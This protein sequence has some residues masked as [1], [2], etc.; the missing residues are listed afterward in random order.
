[1]DSRKALKKNTTLRFSDGYEYTITEELARGGTCIVYNAFYFDTINEKKSVRIKE[2]YP[3]KCN[4]DRGANNELIV[5]VSEAALFE[6]T[7]KRMLQAYQAGNELFQ[8]DGLTNLTANTYNIFNAYNTLYIV[9]AYSQGQELTYQ[10]YNTVKDSIAV[11]KSVASAIG[12]IHS[13]GYLY[14]DIKPSNVFTLEGTTDLIQLFDFDTLIP[15]SDKIEKFTS[16][17]KIS[18]TKGFAALEQQ[19]G[20]YRK[21]GKHSD[22]YGIGALLFYMLFNRVPD[23]FDCE[24]EAEYDFSQSKLLNSA[25][26][27]NLIFKLTDFFHN[28][29]ADY[30]PDRF[31]DMETVIDKLS[32]LQSLSDSTSRF[33]FGSKI[34]SPNFF[35]GRNTESDWI[36]KRLIERKS[37]CLYIVGMGGIGKSTLVRNCIW[38]VKEKLDT[39]LYLNYVDSIEKT[40]TDDFSIHINSV[41]KDK[42]E[43]IRDYY[44]RK[45]SVLQELT[46]DKKCVLVIDNYTGDSSDALQMLFQLGWTIVFIT[47][48]KS[49][50]A[51]YETLEI[52]EFSDTNDLLKLFGKYVGHELTEEETLCANSIIKCVNGH[53]LVVELIAKQIGSP[54]SSLSVEKAAD[55]VAANGFSNVATESVDFQKDSKQYHNTIKQII[56]ELFNADNLSDNQNTLLKTLSLFGNNGVALGKLCEMLKIENRDDFS[57]LY[58]QGWIYIEDNIVSMHPV[59]DELIANWKLSEDAKNAVEKVLLFLDTKLRVESQKEEYPKDYLEYIRRI[60]KVRENTPGSM[61]DKTVQRIIS[62]KPSNR[63]K[64]VYESR[65]ESYCNNAKTDH[66]VVRDWLQLAMTVLDAG[67][68]DIEIQSLDIYKELLYYTIKNT[69]FENEDY[70][71]AKSEDFIALFNHNNEIMLLNIYQCLLEVLYEHGEFDLAKQKI[72]QARKTI[73]GNHSPHIWGLYNYILVGYYDE[74]LNGFYDAESG[75]DGEFLK[76]LIKYANKAISYMRL[77][78]V[79]NAKIL[80][81][82]YYRLKALVL[83]RSGQGTQK[84]VQAILQKVQQLIDKYAQPQSRLMRDYC[85]TLAWYYTYLEEDAGKTYLYLH[86][87][88]EITVII[89]TSELDEIDELL[90]PSAN[91]LLEWQEYDDAAKYLVLSTIMCEKNKDIIAYERK[92]LELLGHLLQVYFSAEEYDKCKTVIALLDDETK[93][94]DGLDIDKYVPLEIRNAAANFTTPGGTE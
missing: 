79:G 52:S 32:E 34:I 19:T 93:Q 13:K 15:I 76:L 78:K 75:E 26:Q 54:V 82:E 25:Y 83:I 64:E 71:L 17:D 24:Q 47:R 5:Q 73:A 69:P 14:L 9:S 3:F 16:G 94:N 36:I 51:G 72:A 23:A 21:I 67:K 61:L 58:H 65:I 81:G 31:S 28:S 53:T 77:S 74:L 86:K 90:S 22:V 42:S 30:Y 46:T 29:L 45:L 10:R 57:I 49:L 39:V 92:R 8:T 60:Q 59:I 11:V 33:I 44:V 91:I 84:Q 89:S 1:M 55:I 18:Y 68:R 12:R 62:S 56:T 7:Q 50:S 70:I 80:L 40:I 35:I 20:D 43:T 48:D 37:G 85:L 38:Q 6:D 41:K 27:D 63:T 2:C 87:A 88:Y 66:S 4:L